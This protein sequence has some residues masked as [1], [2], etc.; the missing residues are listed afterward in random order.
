[1]TIDHK[2]QDASTAI[3]RSTADANYSAK[4]PGSRRAPSGLL[5]AV[6][7]A[8]ALVLAIGLPALLGIG[9][10]PQVGQPVGSSDV[11]PRTQE[12]D[13]PMAPSEA[14]IENALTES[15]ESAIAEGGES[16]GSEDAPP[17][18]YRLLAP[19]EGDW[20]LLDHGVSFA[21]VA[22]SGT[23]SRLWVKST[24]IEPTPAPSTDIGNLIVDTGEYSVLLING[25]YER[26]D[27]IEINVAT[28]AGTTTVTVKVDW[29]DTTIGLAVL[30]AG[31]DID[32]IS[33]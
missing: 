5:I 23:Q 26:P 1:M 24:A 29:T 21:W 31:F 25:N 32:T 16:V 6:L 11:T 12:P 8:A 28:S 30:P 4:A 13:V 10:E 9:E 20:T 2:L 14:D 15:G 18:P 7:S 19:A 27:E 3:R 33:Y 22:E 17:V